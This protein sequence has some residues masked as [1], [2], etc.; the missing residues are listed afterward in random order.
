MGFRGAREEPARPGSSLEPESG[1]RAS[2]EEGEAGGLFS[3]L[4]QVLNVHIL[5]EQ[6]RGGWM[7]QLTV[8]PQGFWGLA[9]EGTKR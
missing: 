4:V 2:L 7:G 6:G 8:S 5:W 1:A 9:N 3:T